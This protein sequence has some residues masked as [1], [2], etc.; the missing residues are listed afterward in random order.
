MELSR[1]KRIDRSTL[2]GERR[3][4]S[5]PALH[6]SSRVHREWVT[7]LAVHSAD[8]VTQPLSLSLSVDGRQVY[9]VLA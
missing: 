8:Q 4:G 7:P 6:R 2:L 1:S 3:W 9:K 5:S